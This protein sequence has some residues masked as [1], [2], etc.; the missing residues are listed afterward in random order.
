MNVFMVETPLQLLNAI[1][2]R[3]YFRLGNNV[4]VILLTGLVQK[5]YFSNLVNSSD[6][7]SVIYVNIRFIHRN[8]DF[9]LHRPANLYERI[10]ELSATLYQIIKRKRIDN[11][12]KH[13]GY[14]DNIILGDYKEGQNDHMRH[15]V[16]KLKHNDVIM[17]DDGTDTILVNEERK[18]YLYH[19]APVAIHG[20]NPKNLKEYFKK[21]F[22]DWD[23]TGVENLTFFTCYNV[24][25][26]K[27]DKLIKNEYTYLR[28]IK[29]KSV[30]NKDTW[31]LGQP[32][33]DDGFMTKSMYL[34]YMQYIYDYFNKKEF[35]YI[36]HPRESRKYAD[37]VVK[38][39]N[40]SE[41]I[42][43]VPVEYEMTVRG[44]KPRCISSFFCSALENC[45]HIFGSD[46]H[47][48]SFYL[49]N[50]HLLRG[51][52]KIGSIY[53]YLSENAKI[54]IEIVRP[55]FKDT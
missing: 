23:T 42:I 55:I 35:Y 39:L 53:E 29:N 41:K 45:C 32:L 38:D 27:G 21:C 54:D 14:A 1:E 44:N 10:L 16:N 33:I 18:N 24:V 50:K 12:A 37:I 6:W 26:R 30:N 31:F 4:M 13:I 8:Y 46:I 47:V 9:C 2:A 36:K 5:H 22:I 52:D 15:F 34:K 49:Q 48:L 19:N 25:V 51:A 7:E 3:Q 20:S 40:I 43:D 11:I 17:L 28:N